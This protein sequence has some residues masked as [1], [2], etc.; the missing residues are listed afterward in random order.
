MES[1]PARNLRNEV[2]AVLRRVEAGGR[3]R[4]TVNGRPVAELVL[5]D[6]R[7]RTMPWEAF[8]RGVT[9][10][11]ADPALGD[12]LRKAFPGTTDDIALE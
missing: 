3:I 5:L 10:A 11:G 6:R 12:D 7:P 9:A 8:W 1:I 2:S 4:V